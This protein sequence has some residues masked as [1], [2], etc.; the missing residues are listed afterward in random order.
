MSAGHDEDAATGDVG[1]ARDD[2]PSATPPLP[3]DERPLIAGRYRVV[4]GDH[5]E[6]QGIDVTDGAPVLVWPS[7]PEWTNARF[8]EQ[9]RA[10]ST[11]RIASSLGS[12]WVL[13]VRLWTPRVV[14]TAPPPAVRPAE[15]LALADAVDCLLQFCDVLARAHAAGFAGLG[16]DLHDVRVHREGDAWRITVVLPHLP[17]RGRRSHA[18]LPP[19]TLS[20]VEGDLWTAVSFF[21]DLLLGREPEP[22]HLFREELP[23]LPRLPDVRLRAALAALL[24]EQPPP[25]PDRPSVFF[26][27]QPPPVREAPPPPIPDAAS[28]AERVLHLARD[29]AEWQSRVAALPRVATVAPAPRDWDRL[30]ELGS[31]ELAA[32]R[33]SHRNYVAYPLAAAYHQRGCAAFARGD[34]EGAM[35][36]VEQ[37]ISIDR[38]ARYLVTRGVL[39]AA[40]G[41][42]EGAFA[43]HDEAVSVAE[44][45][46]PPAG[47][48][49]YEWSPPCDPREPIRAR[50]ARGVARHRRGDVAGAVED[51]HAAIQ[52]MDVLLEEARK[53]E[54]PP[55]AILASLENAVRRAFTTV[56]RARL[57]ALAGSTGSLEVST[58][59]QGAPDPEQ[60]ALRWKLARNL[61]AQGRAAEA[62]A[63][64]DGIV[65]LSP[66]D[67]QVKKRYERLFPS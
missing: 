15:P 28:L 58:G 40:L 1:A 9:E 24:G 48:E 45:T 8:V 2:T 12:P 51:L 4:A 41:D 32:R 59:P 35:R 66:G 5:R 19:Y 33:A 62:R 36:D 13:P 18:D 11:A 46:T 44:S 52:S 53:R 61:L 21:R 31:A 54:A 50:Y 39:R 14:F 22:L 29:P 49:V 65:A 37:A 43:D 67:A 25:P 16:A 20:P 38:W 7:P 34:L 10:E 63:E 56:A 23:P 30:V 27:K 17:P 60:T 26:G 6:E 42:H 55:D 3:R 47:T 57:R 64:A